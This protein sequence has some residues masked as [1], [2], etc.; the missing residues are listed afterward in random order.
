MQLTLAHIGA[1]SNAGD[2]IDKLVQ[3]Y[4]DRMTGFARSEAVAFR[5]EQAFLDW[6]DRQQGR[7]PAI[8]VLLNS[9]GRQMTS[10]S[11]AGWLG[12]RRNAGAQHIVFAVG[13]ANGWSDAALTR[14]QL[15]LSLGTFILA[16]AL[17]R[18]VMAEQL[19]RAYTILAGHPYH[20]GH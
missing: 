18:L 13:P 7:T 8:A 11:F 9:K 14:A 6:L 17:A 4:L 2:P 15:Q 5:S 16:H 3:T 12:E 10:E 19:Y 20:S 1:R